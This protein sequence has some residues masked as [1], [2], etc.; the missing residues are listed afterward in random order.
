MKHIILDLE[1][2]NV[3]SKSAAK[4]IC[5]METI[6]IGAVMLDDNF[7]EISSFKSY[8]KPEYNDC[9]VKKITQLTGITDEMVAF[10]PVF[11]KALKSFTEW[12]ISQGDDIIIHAWSDS[13]YR[14][15]KKEMLLKEYE[16][17]DYETKILA[18]EWLDFQKEFDLHM[19]FMHMLSLKNA[20]NMAGIEFSGTEHDALDDA[21]N[22]AELF[23]AFKDKDIFEKTLRKI[24]EYMEPKTLSSSIGDM[25]DLSLFPCA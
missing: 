3:S 1:M 8:I 12:C 23:R 25:F 19:G 11:E 20:L 7:Q 4:K 18:E 17:A 2:N 24:K 16:I 10:A 15:I 5:K 22:T 9:I 6:E 21:R 14:Q 13:D